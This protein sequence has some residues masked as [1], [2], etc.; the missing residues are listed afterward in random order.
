MIGLLGSVLN[1]SLVGWR[2]SLR[3]Q[4]REDDARRAAG[5]L[6]PQERTNLEFQRMMAQVRS[7]E[8]WS[9]TPPGAKFRK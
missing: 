5:K 9:T 1:G 6:T 2:T 8:Y 3:R 4:E 7:R